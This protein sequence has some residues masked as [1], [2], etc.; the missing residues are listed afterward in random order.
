[1][2]FVFSMQIIVLLRRSRPAA[3]ASAADD[4]DDW[5]GF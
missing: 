4:F 2:L 1:M 5:L 3:V